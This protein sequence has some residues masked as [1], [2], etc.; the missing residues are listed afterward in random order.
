MYHLKIKKPKPFTVKFAIKSPTIVEMP[1]IASRAEARP[2]KNH[3]NSENGNAYHCATPCTTKASTGHMTK[4]FYFFK[5]VNKLYLY[6]YEI[7]Q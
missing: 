6:N 4:G 1:S 7:K 3:V 2:A 5:T